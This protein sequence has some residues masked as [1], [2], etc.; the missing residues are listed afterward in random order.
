[1][2]ALLNFALA[3]LFIFTTLIVKAEEG[4]HLLGIW[5]NEEKDAKIEIYKCSG[6]YCGKIVWLEEPNEEDGTP[7]ID[8][9][10]PDESL[11]NRPLMGLKFLEGF[12]Y[13]GDNLWE[14][15]TIYNS[16]EGKTYSCYL[17]LETETRLKVR[18]YIGFSLLG[19][20]NY[21]ERL[22]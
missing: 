4:D 7:K 11:Q 3:F 1:M 9:E 18:G 21:W 6:K 22:E 10:N 8:D 2:K 19:K 13:D 14:D 15:G 12:S 16:R 20:T 5:W 17:K